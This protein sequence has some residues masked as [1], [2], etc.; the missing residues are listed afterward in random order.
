M[1]FSVQ[2]KQNTDVVT[3][4]V[5]G[6]S[7]VALRMTMTV[8][9]IIGLLIAVFYFHRRYILTEQKMEEKR[10]ELRRTINDND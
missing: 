10:K 2:V 1:P 7:V 9:P 6:G 5:A 8:I 4:A 3:D